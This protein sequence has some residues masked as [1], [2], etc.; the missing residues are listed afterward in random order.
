MSVLRYVGDTSDCS[1]NRSRKFMSG[2]RIFSRFAL[3]HY[4][5]KTDVNLK[6]DRS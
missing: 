2:A 4:V 3:E 5:L 1:N 6:S